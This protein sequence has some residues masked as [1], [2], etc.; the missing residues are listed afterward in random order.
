MKSNLFNI[1]AKRKKHSEIEF[2]KFV[3]KMFLSNKLENDN[4]KIINFII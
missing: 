4:N 2:L 3:Q 1:I